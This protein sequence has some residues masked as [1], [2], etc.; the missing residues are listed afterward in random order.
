VQRRS[1]GTGLGLAICK[2]LVAAHGGAIAAESGPDG[3]TIRFTVA[4]AAGK[5]P[6]APFPPVPAPERAHAHS[7]MS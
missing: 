4:V 1:Q 6:N 5:Q 3:T 7:A 2:A